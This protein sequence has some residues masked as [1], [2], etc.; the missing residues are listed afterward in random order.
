MGAN[1]LRSTNVIGTE[2]SDRLGVGRDLW[3][4]PPVAAIAA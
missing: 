3:N 4:F 1:P 2:E